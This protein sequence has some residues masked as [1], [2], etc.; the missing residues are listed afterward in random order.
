ML[1]K[2]LPALFVFLLI[3]SPVFA[4]E[5]PKNRISMDNAEK[6]AT[7]AQKGT[8][9][10]KELEHEHGE[11]IYS[12]DIRASDKL[13]HEVQVDAKSGKIVSQTIESP[14]DEAAEASSDKKSTK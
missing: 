3:S 4:D 7:Q 1:K 11:W 12:F 13:I 10:S 14:K 8:I 6:I 2:I 5:P 9:E